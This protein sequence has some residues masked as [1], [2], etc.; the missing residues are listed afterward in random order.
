MLSAKVSLPRTLFLLMAAPFSNVYGQNESPSISDLAPKVTDTT[1]MWWRDG[2]PTRV[3][4]ASWVRR[5]QTGHYAFELH[6]ETLAVTHLAPLMPAANGRDPWNTLSPAQLDLQITVDG[7]AYHCQ[8]GGKWTKLSG[9]RLI[10][11]GRYLQRADVTDLT[12]VS[13]DGAS[14]PFHSRFETIAWPKQLGLILHTRPKS[15]QNRPSSG[16]NFL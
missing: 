15:D 14:L 9:P 2:F 7:T 11:S 16:K 13:K 3:T 10:E 1:S 5:I 4:D 6:T 12:F 8:S